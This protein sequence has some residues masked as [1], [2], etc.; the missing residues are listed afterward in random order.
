MDARGWWLAGWLCL[1]PFLP[2]AGAEPRLTG[3][4]ARQADPP[5]LANVLGWVHSLPGHEGAE[6]WQC[7]CR[8]CL[9]M[10]Q[11][12]QLGFVDAF[13]TPRQCTPRLLRGESFLLARSPYYGRAD[14]PPEPF[15]G[16]SSWGTNPS[17]YA[18][19]A[20]PGQT[21]TPEDAASDPVRLTGEWTDEDVLA[22]MDALRRIVPA[23]HWPILERTGKD[24]VRAE[25]TV[26][27]AKGWRGFTVDFRRAGSGWQATTKKPRWE[28]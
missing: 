9:T 5:T 3:P 26:K 6:L 1:W 8:Y 2:S 12:D 22:L 18:V 14:D 19:V 23:Q 17:G 16:W 13:L 10:Q 24:R 27:K 20:A 21:L 25:G 4:A 7:D 28:D 11:C 15:G